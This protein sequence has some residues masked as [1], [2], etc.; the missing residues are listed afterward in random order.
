[1]SLEWSKVD[2]VLF[3]TAISGRNGAR[4][5]L[6][7]EQLPDTD[8]WTG[9]SGAWVMRPT[10]RATAMHLLPKPRSKRPRLRP[11]IG[12][13]LAHLARLPIPDPGKVS[14]GSLSS[15]PIFCRSF[16]STGPWKFNVTPCGSLSSG[17]APGSFVTGRRSTTWL[18]ARPPRQAIDTRLRGSTRSRTCRTGSTCI[19]GDRC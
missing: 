18:P 15:P 4:Y 14:G 11:S 13:T 7:A 2:E 17:S 1:M 8:G 16:A 10:R 19:T 9:P 3:A 12:T 6:I 5:Q